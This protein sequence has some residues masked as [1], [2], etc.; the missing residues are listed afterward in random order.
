MV[1]VEDRLRHA[2]AVVADVSAEVEK[3]RICNV[4]GKRLKHAGGVEQHKRAKHGAPS[5]TE[6]K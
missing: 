2:A 1:P 4:C 6:E 5:D 3:M